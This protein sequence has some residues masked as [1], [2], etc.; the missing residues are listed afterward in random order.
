[1][2]LC[3][4]M[5]SFS[6]CKKDPEPEPEPSSSNDD[7]SSE[8]SSDDDDDGDD[9]IEDDDDDDDDE[10]EWDDEW[11]DTDDDYDDDEEEEEPTYEDIALEKMSTRIAKNSKGMTSDDRTVFVLSPMDLGADRTGKEDCTEMIQ[12]C[13]TVVGNN[14]GGTVYLPA[15]YYR[16]EDVLDIPAGVTLRGEW[17]SPDEG[18][19]GKG[20]ILM[21]YANRG[22]SQDTDPGFISMNSTSTLRNISVWY[23]EQSATNPQPY[24][25][26]IKGSG[27]TVVMN[28][29]L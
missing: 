1:M 6:A 8:P 28:V 29:T 13:L 23:P 19:L 16:V 20:T 21:S 10:I 11:D 4:L 27:H 12:A 15:G 14:G 9:V 7:S 17:M 18:G 25:N 3:M 22:L 2:A 26:T 24:P 5:L